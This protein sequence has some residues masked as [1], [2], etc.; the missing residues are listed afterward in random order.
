MTIGSDPTLQEG[1]LVRKKKRDFYNLATSMT[2]EVDQQQKL[3]ASVSGDT[4]PQSSPLD[5]S[6]PA[7]A[8]TANSRSSGFMITDILSNAN[9]GQAAAATAAAA[10]AAAALQNRLQGSGMA[11]HPS[12]TEFHLQQQLQQFQAHHQQ[13]LHH[14]HHEA[15]S[16]DGEPMSDDETTSS[17][18]AYDQG[19]A[20]N[21]SLLL[22][23]RSTAANLIPFS[24]IKIR[25]TLFDR[26]CQN[27]SKRGA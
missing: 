19:K 5:R 7:S 2:T 15:S 27:Q 16:D 24:S 25:V 8:N 23:L 22:L 11:L 10:A 18:D 4:S 6:P 21:P 26:P 20:K 9:R 14:H 13:Q 17:K 12:L 3:A 1:L